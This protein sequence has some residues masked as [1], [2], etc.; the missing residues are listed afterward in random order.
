MHQ[1][2]SLSKPT[3]INKRGG[4][5]D[6]AGRKHKYGEETQRL[7]IPISLIPQIMAMLETHKKD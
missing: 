7:S 6:G 1:P 5:R 3:I 2:I 4:K